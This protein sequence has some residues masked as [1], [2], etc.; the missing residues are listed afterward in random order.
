MLSVIRE[1]VRLAPYTTLR[2]GGLARYFADIDHEDQLREALQF[3]QKLALP[4]FVL[5]GGS[6][7]LLADIGF[8]GVVIHIVNK[9]IKFHKAKK[10][11]A[12][13]TVAAGEDWDKF[14]QQCVARDLAGL[15]CLSGIPGLVGG[16]PIQNVGAYGQEV[17]T[18]IVTVHA[19][20]RPSNRVVDMS[21]ED[22]HFSYRASVFNTSE[23]DRYIVLSVTYKLKPHG[24]PALH[25]ADLQKYFAQQKSPPTLSEVRDAVIAIRARKGMVIV[26]NDPDSQSAGSFF[27]NPMVPAAILTDIATAARKQHLLS[28]NEQVPSFAMPEGQVKIPAAWLIEKA[29][30]PKGYAQGRVGISSKHTL[31]LINRSN[32]TA[33]ELLTLVERIQNQVQERFGIAL[34]PEPVWVGFESRKPS[35]AIPVQLIPDAPAPKSEANDFLPNPLKPGRK[36]SKPERNPLKSERKKWFV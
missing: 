25:Y 35:E 29:G 30:F 24:E 36:P 8:S 16:T 18:T 19:F 10:D 22:C 31:A 21:N 26:P 15:E 33:N 27:K 20:D 11:A 12:L 7:V 34:V 23:R 13:I 32:A 14:V 17:S 3:A 5:G 2:I 9:G 6:N 4:V 1:N 28:A